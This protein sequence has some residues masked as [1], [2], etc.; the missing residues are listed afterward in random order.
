VQFIEPAPF[1]VGQSIMMYLMV[2]VGGPGYFFG[3]VL[4]S[5]VGVL[6]PEWLRFAQAWYLFVFGTAVVLLMIWLPDGLLS[7]PDRLARQA[8]QA[9]AEASAAAAQ[10]VR[11]LRTHPHH[12]DRP[13]SAPVLKV[14]DLKKAYGAIQAVGGVLRGHARRDL[15]RDRPQRL[16]QDHAVQQHAGP[17]HAG[18]RPH[19][20]Q[21][22]GHHRTS[23][24]GAQPLGVGRTF[25]TLQVFGKMTVRDNLIVAAQEHRGSC[26]AACSRRATPAWATGG[27]ADRPVP[28]APRG[29]QEGRRAELR[30]AEAGGHRDGLHERARPGAARRA[31]RRASTRQPGGRHQH[32]AEGAQPR[33]RAAASSSSSTTWTS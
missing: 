31:L 21:R 24:A 25:Q 19:R 14:T 8:R 33:A 27:R 7:I 4:G 22:R 28:H 18:L 10:G 5:A 26:G 20:A 17:D 13:A 6:L 29:A 3:P 30:P 2:V 15:R 12:H 16:G 11:A 1:T 32:A 23:P 9:S